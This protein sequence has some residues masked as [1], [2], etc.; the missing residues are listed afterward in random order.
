MGYRHHASC[1]CGCQFV[2][3]EAGRLVQDS[4]TPK[5]AGLG[6]GYYEFTTEH[7]GTRVVCFERK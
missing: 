2:V 1:L 3:D 7:H 6:L 4:D 5:L